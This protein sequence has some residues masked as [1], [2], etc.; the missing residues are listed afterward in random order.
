MA[1]DVDGEPQAAI[2]RATYRALCANGYADL[3]MQDIADEAPV[4]KGALHYHY[5]SKRGLFEAF[6]SYIAER[7]LTRLEAADKP[8]AP[9]ADR[10]SAV[11]DAALSPPETAELRDIQRAL[12]ELKAQ[13]P[14]EPAIADEIETWDDHFRALLAAIVAEGIENGEFRPDADPERTARFV[15]TVLAGAQ[16]RQVSVDQSPETARVLLE[17]YVEDRLGAEVE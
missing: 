14:H 9:A 3:T 10:L 11:L 2:M 12:L 8:D 4:S 1:P 16:T 6:Q 5:D 7:F 13:A 15:A 17:T